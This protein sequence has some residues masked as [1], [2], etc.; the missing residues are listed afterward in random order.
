MLWPV[1][2]TRN[3][4]DPLRAAIAMRGPSEQHGRSIGP[5][6]LQASVHRRRRSARVIPHGLHLVS[7]ANARTRHQGLSSKLLCA[8]LERTTSGA[9]GSRAGAMPGQGG[10]V[11]V[12]RSSEG[13]SATRRAS[14]YRR[15]ETW[16]TPLRSMVITLGPRPDGRRSEPELRPFRIRTIIDSGPIQV[17]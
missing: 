4:R 3:Q 5:T 15:V 14:P 7:D 2:P 8:L 17:D 16:S 12:N 6:D 13:Y 11:C 1:I 10:S 9:S